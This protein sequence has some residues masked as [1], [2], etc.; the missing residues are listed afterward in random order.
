MK[1]LPLHYFSV[2]VGHALVDDDLALEPS[3]R[4]RVVLPAAVLAR[5]H[6]PNVLVAMLRE[7][8]SLLPRCKVIITISGT[9]TYN[10]DLSRIVLRPEVVPM[11]NELISHPRANPR[12]ERLTYDLVH[13][14]RQVTRVVHVN[15]NR[16]DCR[17]ENLREI[18][19]V[20]LSV[21][22]E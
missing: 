22:T 14:T 2:E 5:R 8:P 21:D 7:D 1:R 4:W 13:I 16:T 19:N 17:R 10:I 6:P 15:K 20:D 9:S 12:K 11:L 18:S 3:I